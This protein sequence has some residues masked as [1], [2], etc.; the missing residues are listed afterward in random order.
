MNSGSNP[1]STKSFVSAAPRTSS[2]VFAD[3]TPAANPMLASRSRF[4]TIFSKPPK[5]PLTM[6]RMCRVLIVVGCFRPPRDK[7]IMA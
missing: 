7:S 5:A 6:N 3:R 1:K 4:S 2:T